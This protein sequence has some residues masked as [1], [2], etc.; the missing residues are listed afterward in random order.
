MHECI[1]DIFSK[2][3]IVVKSWNRPPGIKFRGFEFRVAVT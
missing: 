2:V 1:A 3:K